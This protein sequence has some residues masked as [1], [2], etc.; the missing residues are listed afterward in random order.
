MAIDINVHISAEPA[1][2][3]ALEAI[4]NAVAVCKITKLN[5][6]AVGPQSNPPTPKKD[7]PIESTKKAEKPAPEP[8]AKQEE[9]KAE[10]QEAEPVK[11]EHN[12]DDVIAPKLQ[13]KYREMVRTYCEKV[14]NDGKETVRKW[15][16]DNGFER[17]SQLTY[18]GADDFTQFLEGEVSRSA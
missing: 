3:N 4:A 8:Q 10:A 5:D 11:P 14:G 7:K 6:L 17:I 15:L 18:K 12:P 1:L 9:P 13:A 16:N 2:V